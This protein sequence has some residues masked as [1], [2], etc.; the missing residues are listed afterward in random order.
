MFSQS[1][2]QEWA[3]RV[4]WY[5]VWRHYAN[6][7]FLVV[8]LSATCAWVWVQSSCTYLTLSMLVIAFSV[9]VFTKLLGTPHIPHHTILSSSTNLTF[10]V[11]VINKPLQFTHFPPSQSSTPGSLALPFPLPPLDHDLALCLFGSEFQFRLMIDCNHSLSN[12]TKWSA[13]RCCK[14]VNVGVWLCLFSFK[15]KDLSRH[16]CLEI[17]PKFGLLVQ[18]CRSCSALERYVQQAEAW[19]FPTRCFS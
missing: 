2:I 1:L 7:L 19:Y 14:A 17:L 15:F 16:H 3:G 10:S 9:L 13:S 6:G 12:E 11:L 18:Q 4:F 8:K 5:A